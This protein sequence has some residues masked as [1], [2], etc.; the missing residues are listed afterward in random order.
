TARKQAEERLS[1]LAYHDALTDL[2]NR[3]LVEREMDLALARARRADGSAALLFIDLDDF[4]EVN[5]RLGHAAGDRLLASIAARLR[6]VLRDTDVLARQGGDEFL[7]LLADLQEGAAATAEQVAGKLLHALREPFVVSGVELRTG[8]SIGISLYPDDASDTE[9]LL[10]HADAAMYRAKAGGGGRWAVHKGGAISNRR[11]GITSE[12]RAA[13]TAGELELHYQPVFTLAGERQM[14][15]VEALLRWR[16]P[17]RGLLCADAFVPLAEQTSAGDELMDWVMREC[18]RQAREWQFQD[19]LTPLIGLN[20]SASQL[21]VPG[22]VARLS[23]AV[24]SHGLSPVRFAIELTES[25][26]T[27]D[28]TETLVVIEELRA[29]GFVVALDDFGAGYSS[30]SRLGDLGFDVIKIDGR[31]LVDVPSDPIA[32]RLLEAALAVAAAC[33]TDVVA[34]GVDSEAQLQFL[35]S[36]G[37]RRAQG[38]HLCEALTP[39]RLTPLLRRQLITEPLP[40]RAERANSRP[41]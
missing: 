31:M 39:S 27:V 14:T 40:D 36:R 9:V 18:F 19:G 21:L 25:A 26:W 3:T 24:R 34:E 32:V 13:I 17:E 8:A 4:K 23:A 35:I 41:R 29:A 28:A 7:V 37:V 6:G 10:R 2:P 5:D 33:G 1:Y 30:L 15:S 16:H 20:V 22:F 12:V 11:A 38:T